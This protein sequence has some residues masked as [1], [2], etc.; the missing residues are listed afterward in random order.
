[1]S[2]P[3]P[4]HFVPGSG[5]IRKIAPCQRL[6]RSKIDLARHAMKEVNKYL[7]LPEVL[8]LVYNLRYR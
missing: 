4:W 8:R 6:N 3:Q 2:K 1:M 5:I 7:S